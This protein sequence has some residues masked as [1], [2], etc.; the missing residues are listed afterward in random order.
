[1][2]RWVPRARLLSVVAGLALVTVAAVGYRLSEP[3]DFAVVRGDLGAPAAYADGSVVVDDVRVGSV[4]VT[5]TDE[6]VTTPG[7]FVVVRVAARAAA[8]SSGSTSCKRYS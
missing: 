2:T 4:L 3:E 6:R 7:M 5:S 8:T 1:M